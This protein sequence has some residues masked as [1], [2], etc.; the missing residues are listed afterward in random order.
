MK[1][2]CVVVVYALVNLKVQ[3]S[4]GVMCLGLCYL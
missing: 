1:L 4:M 3:K 2:A